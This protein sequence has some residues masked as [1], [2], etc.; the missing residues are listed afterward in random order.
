MWSHQARRLT[1]V[2][3]FAVLLALARPGAQEPPRNAAPQPPVFRSG[4][5]LV[6]IDV[7]V[8]DKRGEFVRG[9]TRNDFEVIEDGVRQP[10]ASFQFLDIPIDPPAPATFNPVEADVTTNTTEGR[11]YVMLLDCCAPVA[12]SAA[13]GGSLRAPGWAVEFVNRVLRPNDLMA[14]V[15]VQ[16]N[17]SD[18]QGF[19]SNKTLLSTSINKFFNASSIGSGGGSN[20]PC[21]VLKE[22]VLKLRSTYEAIENVSERLGNVNGRR[23]AILWVNA[24]IP[25]DLNADLAA[26]SAANPDSPCGGAAMAGSVASMHRDAIRIA[27]RN[28]VAIYPVDPA[29]LTTSLGGREMGRVAAL[30]Q[31]AEDTGGEAVTGTNNYAAAYDRI[32]RQNSTYYLI[33]YY[34]RT[35]YRDGKFHN[36]TVRVRQ[37]DVTVHS[38][39]GYF[40][41]LTP[42]GAPA[43][44]SSLVAG[45]SPRGRAALRSPAPVRGLGIDFVAV[46][47]QGSS[48]SASVVIE[49]DMRGGDLHLGSGDQVEVSYIPIDTRGKVGKGSRKVFTLNFKAATRPEVERNGLRFV[50]RIALPPGRH[51]LRFAVYQPGGASGSVVAQVDVPDFPKAPL[52]VSGL[53]VASSA[54][55][56]YTLLSDAA[57]KAALSADPT[58]RRLFTRNEQLAVFAEVYV[59]AGRKSADIDMTYTIEDRFGDPLMTQTGRVVDPAPKGRAGRSGYLARFPLVELPAGTYVLTGRAVSLDGVLAAA[60][61][62]PFTITDK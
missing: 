58:S 29:G 62:I 50:D 37:R 17:V 54:A 40:A 25:F 9:L 2:S 41:P 57:I 45:L 56:P 39:K 10:I 19:T 51:E 4:V 11:M 44:P 16:G 34:P 59:G 6:E 13:G 60:R 47:F 5:Q 48:S 49:A 28:N 53:V 38:K 43:D 1:V 55:G 14:V 31:V 35:E 32:V 21:D 26:L 33:G 36:V 23:K 3:A 61:Q 42:P 8:T 52:A 27:T 18:G 15:H 46:P 30:R 24:D 20:D 22:K 12:G 7:S